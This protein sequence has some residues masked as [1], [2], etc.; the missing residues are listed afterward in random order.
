M[1]TF[2]L[3]KATPL[4]TAIGAVVVLLFWAIKFFGLRVAEREQKDGFRRQGDEI[5]SEF[6]KISRDHSMLMQKMVDM[7]DQFW[8]TLNKQTE[9]LD[10]GFERQRDLERNIRDLHKKIVK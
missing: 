5:F 4:L 1:E 7:Q 10:D 9:I 3:D 2:L 6:V 8:K